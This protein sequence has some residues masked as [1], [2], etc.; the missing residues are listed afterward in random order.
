M[1]ADLPATL[2]VACEMRSCIDQTQEQDWV[3]IDSVAVLD[4]NSGGCNWGQAAE[5]VDDVTE[6]EVDEV[7]NGGMAWRR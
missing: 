4:D 6:S 5:V 7:G 1:E 3:Q 2:E